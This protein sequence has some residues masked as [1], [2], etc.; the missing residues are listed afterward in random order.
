MEVLSHLI[1]IKRQHRLSF[2]PVGQCIYCGQDGG[3][4]RLTAEHI[5][6][7]GLNGHLVLP[8]SSCDTCQKHINEFERTALRKSLN[9]GRAK[10]GVRSKKGEK[11]KVVK[12][13]ASGD[14]HNHVPVSE[15]MP[16]LVIVSHYNRRADILT[17]HFS[18]NPDNATTTLAW[19]GITVP[20][21]S[22]PVAIRPGD[23]TRFV[24]KIAHSYAVASLGL[25]AFRPYL[26]GHILGTGEPAIPMFLGIADSFLPSIEGI[27]K[28]SS[29]VENH[30]CHLLP[31]MG[32]VVRNLVI[33]R[34]RFFP[35]IFD[36]PSYEIV[37][38]EI[39]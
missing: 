27:V 3:E 1:G 4:A 5:V 32:S 25:N 33:I 17:G 37:A 24:A 16:A 2:Y 8:D 35:L 29:H 19:N 6:P 22:G 11:R 39:I 7:D 36:L 14:G 12:L 18:S 9:L 28:I 13:Y 23:F 34:L 15:T 20:S 21:P 30:N 26:L 38:G 10:F 31:R